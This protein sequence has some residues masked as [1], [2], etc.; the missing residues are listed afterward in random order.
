MSYLALHRRY[1]LVHVTSPPDV[2]VFAALVPKLL[3]AKI[4]L[5]IHDIGPELYM[6]KLGVSKDK[7]M[8]C[9]LR[10]LEKVSAKFSLS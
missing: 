7:I 4:I 2:I 6:R 1:E 5:D 9:C 8:I 3:G 10:L